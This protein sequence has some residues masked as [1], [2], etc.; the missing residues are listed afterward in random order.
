M[1]SLF[2]LGERKWRRAKKRKNIKLNVNDR[3]DNGDNSDGERA[4][5]AKKWKRSLKATFLWD[6]VEVGWGMF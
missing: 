1:G 5:A 6:L 2:T 4:S 3:N